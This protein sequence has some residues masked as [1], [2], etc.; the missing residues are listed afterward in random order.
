MLSCLV[1]E[2]AYGEVLVKKGSRVKI[3]CRAK[4]NSNFDFI[5]FQF[6]SIFYKTFTF[7]LSYDVG[8]A[9]CA[10]PKVFLF[11]Y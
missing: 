11:F 1:S 10:P 6:K 7:N 5:V 2:P 4:E 8:G 9:L 3:Q